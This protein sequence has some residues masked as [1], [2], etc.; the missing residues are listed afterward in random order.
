MYSFSYMAPAFYTVYAIDRFKAGAA[1][2]A[3]HHGLMATNTVANLLLGILADRR[4]N[5]PVLQIS[6]AT[7][8]AAALLAL[9]APSLWWMYPVFALNSVVYAGANMG[10]A[11]CRLSSPPARRYR[12]TSP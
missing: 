1:G 8:I 5:K 7:A 2:G 3:L 10:A 9:V 12:R 4:G 11:I 6:M